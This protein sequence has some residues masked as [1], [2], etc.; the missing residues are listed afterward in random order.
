MS[1]NEPLEPAEALDRFF[2]L[3]REEAASNP[4]FSRRLAQALGC[5]VIFRGDEA[6]AA[7]DPVMVA[8]EGLDA[9]R[10]T[11]LTFAPKDLR[12]LIKEHGLA[13]QADMKGKTKAPMLVDLMW[14]GACS[15]RRDLVPRG[16]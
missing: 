9:F 7:V 5:S 6:L 8:G 15:K 2:T 3:I 4:A 13:T 10:Q 14:E 11:F 1:K 12:K 16:R